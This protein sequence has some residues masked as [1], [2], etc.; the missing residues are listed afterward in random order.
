MLT[1]CM[2]TLLEGERQIESIRTYSNDS[3][4]KRR[5]WLKQHTG[6]CIKRT[7]NIRINTRMRLVYTVHQSNIRITW[8]VLTLKNCIELP[9]KANQQLCTWILLFFF[10]YIFCH[11][12]TTS[13]WKCLISRFMKDVNKQWRFFFPFLNFNKFIHLT[14][15]TTCN[16][17]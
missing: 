6:T 4:R 17:R 8:E 15:W 2:N 9:S 13:T 10:S 5:S 16:N 12:C 14:K 1:T 7:G 3:V 11:Q